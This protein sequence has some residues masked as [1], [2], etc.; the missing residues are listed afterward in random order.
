MLKILED[1]KL[2]LIVALVLAAA[3]PGPAGLMGELLI[4]AIMLTV[5]FS[6]INMDFFV[7]TTEE[8][9]KAAYLLGIGYIILTGVL[10]LVA[11]FIPNTD[12][13]NG[14]ILYAA[15]PP[16]VMIVG[17]SAIWGGSA[18]HAL[19]G[20]LFSYIIG[21]IIT[22]LISLTFIGNTI[23]TGKLIEIMIYVFIIPLLAVLVI[24]KISKW[25]FKEVKPTINVLNGLVFY[26]LIGQSIDV[27][28]MHFE[29]FVVSLAL[30]FLV[31][32][33][34]MYV[35]S[36]LSNRNVDMVLF[37]SGCNAIPNCTHSTGCFPDNT[38]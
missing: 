8:I 5:F 19:L 15:F 31:S 6:M 27:L 7:P 14:L 37:E 3:L 36:R 35:I 10:I 11:Q 23:E 25:E 18:R 22:P 26:I 13:K 38:N 4:P 1:I 30:I 24:R 28:V 21:I 33:A 2:I 32:V 12:F 9:K 17:F 16:A 20:E 34:L 29:E